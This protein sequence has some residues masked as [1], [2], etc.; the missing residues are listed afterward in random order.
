MRVTFDGSGGSLVGVRPVVFGIAAGSLG[1]WGQVTGGVL[2]SALLARDVEVAV[3]VGASV[4]QERA[5]LADACR[6]EEE[7]REDRLGGASPD[8]ALP[9]RPE[10]LVGVVLGEAVEAF[11]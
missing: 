7:R 6:G 11:L 4:A 2:A 10:C 5:D 8:T 1:P 3:L 9:G